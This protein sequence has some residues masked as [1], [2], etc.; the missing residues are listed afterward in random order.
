MY[1]IFIHSSVDGHL[2]CLHVLAIVHSAAMDTE[3]VCLFELWFSLSITYYFV[4]S[5]PL[6]LAAVLASASV[7][8]R[9]GLRVST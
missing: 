2:G 9:S 5:L 6:V 7:V 3:C 1:H 8:L 4:I